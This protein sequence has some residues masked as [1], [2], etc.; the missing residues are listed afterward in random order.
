MEVKL[1][2]NDKIPFYTRPFPSKEEEKII[3]DKEIRKG[4]LFG[5]LRKGLCSYSSPIILIPR[6]VTVIPCIATDFI[7]FQTCQTKLC[8]S[9]G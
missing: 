5:T 1:E 8:F 3:V 9:I 2:L 7:N 4:C 6:K